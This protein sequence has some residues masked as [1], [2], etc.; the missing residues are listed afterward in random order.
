MTAEEFSVL[1]SSAV[2]DRPYSS[3]SREGGYWTHALD[4]AIIVNNLTL[5]TCIHD[6]RFRSNGPRNHYRHCRGCDG[7]RD[8]RIECH[9][10]E[11]ANHTEV[12]NRQHRN[13]KLHTESITRR[14]V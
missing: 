10:N 7:G 9:S 1:T 4:A 14:H 3:E 8:S 13:R 11:Y 5:H 6:F 12:R 2:I